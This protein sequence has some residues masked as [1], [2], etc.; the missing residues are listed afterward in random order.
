M[1]DKTAQ[2]AGFRAELRIRQ[3]HE[4]TQIVV[5]L[6]LPTGRGRVSVGARVENECLSREIGKRARQN[7]AN[8]R[9]DQDEK[10]CK[11][12]LNRGRLQGKGLLFSLYSLGRFNVPETG[13]SC[14][15]TEVNLTV[16]TFDG[17]ALADSDAIKTVGC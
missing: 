17:Q 14:G 11:R 8:V 13:I 16:E 9:S 15:A 10:Y 5:R 12:L 6:L 7:R 4:G 1:H 3:G 2:A